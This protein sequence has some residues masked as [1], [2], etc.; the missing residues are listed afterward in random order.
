MNQF[1]VLDKINE[2]FN[3]GDFIPKV[4]DKIKIP[5][6]KTNENDNHKFK[7]TESRLFL[8]QFQ[9]LILILNLGTKTLLP[10]PKIQIDLKVPL[11]TIAMGGVEVCE[12]KRK[13]TFKNGNEK[14]ENEMINIPIKPGTTAG[15]K[16]T[17]FEKGDIAP[18][19]T[20]ADIIYTVRYAPHEIF[21]QNGV[22]LKCFHKINKNE[23]KHGT[24][25][26]IPTLYGPYHMKFTK[27]IKNGTIRD[28]HNRGL[29]HKHEP[30]KKGRLTIQFEIVEI[31]TESSN[32]C[33]VS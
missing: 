27:D 8:F 4:D 20:Q 18:G 32:N 3:L 10:S 12:F 13:I 31:K 24:Q 22:N 11:E 9:F 15:S 17:I 19:V 14:F 33:Q 21:K 26:T 7:E 30:K 28:L 6:I 2:E 23:T 5:M 16:I 1:Y 25:I 29:P